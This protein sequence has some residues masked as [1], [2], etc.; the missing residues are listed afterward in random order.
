MPVVLSSN[1]PSIRECQSLAANLAPVGLSIGLSIGVE[2]QGGAARIKVLVCLLKIDEKV[3][4]VPLHRQ[5][6]CALDGIILE[7]C[8]HKL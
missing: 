5:N 4:E 8:Q 6:L 3:F 2:P 7:V 1:S